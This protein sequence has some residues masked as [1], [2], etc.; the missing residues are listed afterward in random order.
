MMSR[1]VIPTMQTACSCGRSHRGRRAVGD[2]AVPHLELKQDPQPERVVGR[3]AAV[4]RDQPLYLA[5]PEIATL[6][7]AAIEQD[8]TRQVTQLV[9]E[10]GPQRNC[11]ALLG[12]IHD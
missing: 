10:P 12:P 4:L 7:C 11:E 8:L 6:L 3:F 2:L 5:G 1:P 9:T